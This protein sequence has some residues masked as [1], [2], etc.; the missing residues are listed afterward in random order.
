[1]QQMTTEVLTLPGEFSQVNVDLGASTELPIARGTCAVPFEAIKHLLSDRAVRRP[2]RFSPMPSLTN[3]SL[4][5]LAASHPA[6]K[7][8]FEGEE[9]RPF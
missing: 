1:M 5:R 4:K 6:P 8:W 7:E 2:T 9:D 3:E